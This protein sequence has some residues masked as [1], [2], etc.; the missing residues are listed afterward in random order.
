MKSR[1]RC[2]EELEQQIRRSYTVEASVAGQR[3][4][5]SSSN[6]TEEIEKQQLQH[7]GAIEASVETQRS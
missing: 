4:K 1:N 5:R 2:T 3:R 7:K 6:C